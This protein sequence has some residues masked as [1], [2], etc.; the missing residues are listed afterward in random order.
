M[1][2][3]YDHEGCCYY[4]NKRWSETVGTQCIGWQSM[5]GKSLV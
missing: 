5:E 1:R 3:N 2:H 4:C